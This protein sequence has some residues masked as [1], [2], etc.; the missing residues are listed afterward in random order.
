MTYRDEP[1]FDDGL[2]SQSERTAPNPLR[3][4]AAF[5]FVPG[6]AAFVLATVQPGYAGLPYFEAVLRSAL[7][8]AIFGAYPSTLIFGVP[9]Y[10]VLRKNL[11]ATISNCAAAGAFVAAL[12]W[13]L[14]GV[15][16]SPDQASTNGR[17][18]VVDGRMTAYGWLE[19][20]QFLLILGAVG[21][22]AGALFWLIA[23]AGD[24]RF[25]TAV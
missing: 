4:I 14:L 13:F 19:L 25:K 20:G 8:F 12:P 15:L 1:V 18:T 24:R 2:L 22:V 17:A 9:I 10:L 16:A 3:L 5:V 23:V 21:A 7:L 6:L 11:R